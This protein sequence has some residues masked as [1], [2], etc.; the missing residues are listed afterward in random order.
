MRVLVIAE[1]DGHALLSST[2]S[3]IGFA[4]SVASSTSGEVSCLL[5]VHNLD[6]VV[7]DA[8]RYAHVWIADH[9]ALSRPVADRCAR[10]IANVARSDDF[11]LLVAAS[12][13]TGKDIV[14][15][16]AGLLGGNMASDVVGHACQDGQLLLQ[17][18]MYAGACLATVSL[19]GKPQV[20]TIRPSAYAPADPSR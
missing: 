15:R 19:L 7:K 14:S 2:R 11:D 12:N 10:V 20:V 8:Q 18:P 4:R 1:H 13:T 3:A 17:R 16:A 6:A 9:P 5:M